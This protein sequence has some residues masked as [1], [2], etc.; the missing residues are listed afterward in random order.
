[1][2]S[3]N[4][5]RNKLAK[6]ALG[7]YLV[8]AVAVHLGALGAQLPAQL[9]T[10]RADI[11]QHAV[12]RSANFAFGQTVA[13]YV[14]F[15]N[16]NIP[17]DV[18]V[19]LPDRDSA[20]E[21]LTR[22]A[23]MQLFLYPRDVVNCSS[24]YAGCA[25]NFVVGGAVALVSDTET[26][27][28]FR[29]GQ[30]LMFNDDW[31]L[32]LPDG[33]SAQGA[34]LIG[35]SSLFSVALA[36]ITALLFIAL[37]A[38]PAVLLVRRALPGLDFAFQ[39]ALGLGAGLG[40]LSFAIYLSLL[41]GAALSPILVGVILLLFGLAAW[42]SQRLWPI[43]K[44]PIRLSLD[45]WVVAFSILALLAAFIG[46]G[47]AY[48]QSDEFGLWA[49]KGYGILAAG[50]HSGA[51]EWGSTPA[52][53]PLQVP[54]LIGAFKAIFG[55]RLPEAKLLFPLFL[56]GLSC[57]VYSY[58]RRFTEKKWAGLATL[59]LASTPLL[60]EQSALAY[61]NLPTTFYLVV[62][63]LLFSL[64][65]NH[66]KENA[67]RY[68][69]AGSIFLA[70]AAWTRLEA[71]QIAALILILLMVFLLRRDRKIDRRSIAALLIP[72]GGF[73]AI[74]LVSSAQLYAGKG[75]LAGAASSAFTAMLA[76]NFREAEAAYILGTLFKELIGFH[77]WGLLFWLLVPLAVAILLKTPRLRSN[78]VLWSGLLVSLLV[79]GGYYL[80]AFDAIQGQDI[81]WW[82]STGMSRM[83]MPGIVLLWLGALQMLL[84]AQA[85]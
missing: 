35:F 27:V 66:P 75:F 59:P 55:D 23:A 53:Y 13:D 76:G 74:W 22:T 72:L 16:A 49:P 29:A 9:R 30:V 36:F 21:A 33:R 8:V 46:V 37:V 28:D 15:L 20:P 4:L 18:T 61:A 24:D 56:L 7:F 69:M 38:T 77:D 58:L 42:G 6:L 64:A 14:L 51:N 12:W 17:V 47:S 60:F 81:S 57:V 70:L 85:K 2:K 11:G 71:L 79:L 82:V 26:F 83:L 84:Q 65:L 44:T 73:A 41:L 54:V 31:G 10:I 80:L 62:A 50:L 1:M 43:P 32:L 5:K 39:L 68:Y 48:R 19:V 52:A 3:G 78:F 63:V 25:A 45:S 67:T 34:P 40:F